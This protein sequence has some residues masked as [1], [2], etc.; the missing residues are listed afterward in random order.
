MRSF[1]MSATA[2]VFLAVTSSASQAEVKQVSYPLVRV[3][4]APAFSPD[5]TFVK[6]QAAF[7]AAVS[8][9]DA[10]ALFSLVGP[11]FLWMSRGELN[12]QFNFGNAPLD[13]FKVLFGFSQSGENTSSAAAEGPLW[14]V[15]ATFAA[16]KAFYVATGTL[17]CGPSS[18]VLA[19][20]DDFNSAK[21]KIGADASI[22]WYYTL[23]DTPV[24]SSPIDAGPPL[25]HINQSAVPVLNVFPPPT[26][27]QP[28][29]P[30]THLQVLLPSGKTGWIPLAAGLPLVTD[31]LCYAVTADGDWKIAAFDQAE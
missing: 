4:L 18:A 20:E 22:E 13:N 30:V 8:A 1:L 28:K 24:T 27:G 17:V 25:G 9:K 23:A 6:M 14:D 7:A 11:T 15:L 2:V 29:S 12:D 10:Q 21:R 5:D 19:D 16:D 31:R 3:K 26:A